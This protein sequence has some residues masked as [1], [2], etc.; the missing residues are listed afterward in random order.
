MLYTIALNTMLAALR[1]IMNV[2][3]LNAIRETVVYLMSSTMPNE[4][5]HEAA[6]HAAFVAIEYAQDANKANANISGTL[7]DI[8][9]KVIYLSQ[10][11]V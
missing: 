7:I 1:L 6:K 11:R 10:K 3:V 4:A 8:A 5:K 9:I 2:D